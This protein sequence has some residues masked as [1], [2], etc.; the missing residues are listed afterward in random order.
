MKAKPSPHQLRMT[1]DG[2]SLLSC[3]GAS[4]LVDTAR[5][6]GLNHALS[7]ELAP[8]RSPW[9]IHD[10]GKIILDLATAVG[11]GADCLA[12]I[13]VVR[14]QPELFGSVASDPTVSRLIT[15]ARPRCTDGSGGA[16]PRPGR[17]PREGLVHSIP[18]PRAGTPHR[19][20]GRHDRPVPLREGR[21][22]RHLE[23][24]LRFPPAAGIHRAVEC[25]GPGGHGVVCA[26]VRT[27][28]PVAGCRSS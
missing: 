25:H 24:D 4:L 21:R 9:A 15:K 11:L 27:T 7:Q 28:G 10:P 26:Q 23:T 20:P 18:G 2:E 1:G 16:A 6:S 3:A 22:H 19:R 13:G 17:G 14:A 8:W 5:F 12:D